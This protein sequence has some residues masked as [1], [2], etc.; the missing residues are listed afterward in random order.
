MASTTKRLRDKNKVLNHD[1]YDSNKQRFKDKVLVCYDVLLEVGNE[2]S[3]IVF[4]AI[5]LQE[6]DPVLFY[7][8]IAFLVLTLIVRLAIALRPLF[9]SKWNIREGSYKW[10]WMG[11]LLSLLEPISGQWLIDKTID[12]AKDQEELKFRRE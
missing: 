12:K 5:T 3:D 11:V 7:I 2:V 8:S 4:T 1:L 10:Y 6:E 9:N